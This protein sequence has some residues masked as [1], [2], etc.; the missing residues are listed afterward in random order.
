MGKLYT[1]SEISEHYRVPLA[2]VWSWIRNKK[3]SAIK[4]GREYRIP[5]EAVEE[6]ESK[7]KTTQKKA[8]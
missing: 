7:N 3:I 4:I 8:E 5:E 1:C 2:T 6:F